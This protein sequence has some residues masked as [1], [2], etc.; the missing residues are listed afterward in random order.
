MAPCATCSSSTTC[1]TCATG[2]EEYLDTCIC[3]TGYL[4]PG[5]T[6]CVSICPF[7]YYAETVYNT[8]ISCNA[9]CYS[10]TGPTVDEC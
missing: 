8:C 3:S 1:L 10:C 2:F 5:S 7:N 6:T 9:Y 4:T